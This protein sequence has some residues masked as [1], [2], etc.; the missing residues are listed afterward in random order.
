MPIEALGV[1]V[2]REGGAL[3]HATNFSVGAHL[4]FRAARLLAQGISGREEF[5]AAIFERHHRRK[6]DAPSGTALTLQRHLT[7]TDSA[8]SFPITSERVG[9]NPGEHLLTVDGP[10][11]TLTLTHA[12]RDRSVFAAG[13]V[14][15]A[16][17]LPGRTGVFGF[18]SVLFGDDQ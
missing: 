6:L 14:L 3:L 1:T 5:D 13:A 17:W 11:E 2:A 16:E 8:R 12:V 9:A 18:E 7:K 4:M 15:A 10:Y